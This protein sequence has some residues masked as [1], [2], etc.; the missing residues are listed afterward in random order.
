[1][2]AVPE[3]PMEQEPQRFS[4]LVSVWVR[5]LETIELV[6]SE[7]RF[8][9]VLLLAILSGTAG[10]ATILMG[11]GIRGGLLDWQAL[12]ICLLA[13]GLLG[14]FN[15]YFFAAIA[16]WIGRSMGGAAS[17]QA[18]RAVFAWGG[19]PTVLGFAVVLGIL[20]V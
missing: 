10:M 18:L 12:L 19:L 11:F 13:G 9:L 15:V 3:M 17:T 16:G 6:V 7:Q 20:S 14:L 8:G 1:M 4:P 2:E 5:P